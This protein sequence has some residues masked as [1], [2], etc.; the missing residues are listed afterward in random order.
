MLMLAPGSVAQV[1]NRRIVTDHNGM[2]REI[3]CVDVSDISHGGVEHVGLAS[4][5][6]IDPVRSHHFNRLQELAAVRSI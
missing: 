3:F 4:I 2:A 6:E 5:F 1:V